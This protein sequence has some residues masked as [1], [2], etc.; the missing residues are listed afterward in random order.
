MRNLKVLMS[1]NGAAYRGFQRQR[2]AVTVQGVVEAAIERL[3]KAP[4]P[5]T[6]CGRT[7]AGVHAREFCFNLRAETSI[8]NDGFVKGM[9][10]LLPNDMAISSCED[11]NADFHAGYSATG[12]EYV[13][14]INN[15]V[16]RDVFT[17]D[18][19]LFHP[20][21]IDEKKMDSAAGLFVGEHDFSAYCKAE[22]LGVILSKKRGAVRKIYD[23]TV[24]RD[25]DYVEMRVSGNGFLHNMVRI[26]AG[27]LI[28]VNAGKLT[29]DDIAASFIRPDRGRTGVTLPP[30]GLYL[31]KV[32]Y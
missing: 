12:K 27:T 22:S 15:G 11:V 28:Y 4:V 3:L 21:P 17:V 18:T 7:D 16:R 24:T 20:F 10:S 25:G 14:L 13:Y 32:F 9:N 5:V 29:E 6:G 1:Y 19:A 31:N 2:N 23:F 26:M 8:P 30:R